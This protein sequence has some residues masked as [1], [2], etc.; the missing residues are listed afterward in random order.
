MGSPVSFQEE[1]R[2]RFG[3]YCFSFT[4]GWFG[5]A[6]ERQTGDRLPFLVTDRDDNLGKRS[7]I[8]TTANNHT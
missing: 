8:T 2:Y 5:S 1:L 3:R 4:V 7:I 6:L